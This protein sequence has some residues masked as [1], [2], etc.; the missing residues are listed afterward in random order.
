MQGLKINFRKFIANIYPDI[1]MLWESNLREKK[2][3]RKII[4]MWCGSND[5]Q[6]E[7]L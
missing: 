7:I 1:K 6:T 5:L 2:K 4:N 3:R